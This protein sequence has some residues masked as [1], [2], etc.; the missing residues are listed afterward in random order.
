MG[1]LLDVWI[2]VRLKVKVWLAGVARVSD[3][4]TSILWK[5]VCWICPHPAPP[6]LT[7][8]TFVVV[9]LTRLRHGCD[10]SRSGIKMRCFVGISEQRSSGT[11]HYSPIFSAQPLQLL[12]P[13]NGTRSQVTRA[14]RARP[15]PGA[16]VHQTALGAEGQFIHGCTCSNPLSRHFL[17]SLFCVPLRQLG[18]EC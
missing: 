18:S 6:G 3:T 11:F 1:A 12:Q 15:V 16:T 4:V 14:C 7:Q 17:E 8:P 5:R 10:T 13:P 2:Y 9:L